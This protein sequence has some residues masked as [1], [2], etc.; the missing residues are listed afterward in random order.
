MQ[1]VSARAFQSESE[2][3]GS[4][5]VTDSIQNHLD[6]FDVATFFVLIHFVAFHLIALHLP[7]GGQIR[8]ICLIMRSVDRV[9][10]WFNG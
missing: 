3:L 2:V 8:G 7:L 5:G 1:Q 6:F 4:A 10:N 9:I